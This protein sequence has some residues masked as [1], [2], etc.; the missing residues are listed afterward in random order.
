MSK[1]VLSVLTIF[2][3]LIGTSAAN[4]AQPTS[5]VSK[6]SYSYE[7]SPPPQGGDPSSAKRDKL[8]V[9]FRDRR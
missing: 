2:L 9:K 8:R 5:T 1:P 6:I 4:S 3:V 7:D